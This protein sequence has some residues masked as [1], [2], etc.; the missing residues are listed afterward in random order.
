M[1]PASTLTQYREPLLRYLRSR[2]S[3][4]EDVAQQTLLQVY[5]YVRDGHTLDKPL[6][7]LYQT[8]KN[9]IRKG[10]RDDKMARVTEAVPDI[11]TFAYAPS[12]ES[13]AMSELELEAACEAID[14]LPR[15]CRQV[16]VLRK[17]YQYSHQE[18]AA[19]MGISVNT[20]KTY[21]KRGLAQIGAV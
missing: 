11:E 9:V 7:F 4:P 15:K 1:T 18:I 5:V 16:F 2:V 21:L 17:V 14:G 12:A 20:V 10:Y 6:A 19:D 8:A 3:D 13:G